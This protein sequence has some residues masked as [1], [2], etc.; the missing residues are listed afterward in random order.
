MSISRR[1]VL[2]GGLGLAGAAVLGSAA[3]CADDP[4]GQ[5][6]RLYRSE[7]PLPARFVTPFTAPPVKRPDAREDGTTRYTVVQRQAAVEILP[8]VL[9]DVYGY[10][11]LFP[12]PTIRARRGERVV[13]THRNL[14]PVPTVVHLHGGHTPAASDG[15]PTDL[16]LPEGPPPRTHAGHAGMPG[17]AGDVAH[18]T[19]DH[20]YPGDQPA[21]TLWYH[22]HRMDF[23]AP[24]V[25]RGLAGFHLIGDAD[26]DRLPLPGGERDLP[27][28]IMDR[29]FGPDGELRYP[30]LDG[31][32]TGRPG[33][34]AG[35]V[36]GVLGDVVLVNGRPWPVLDVAAARYRFRVLNASNARRYD[37][38]LDPAPTVGRA[39]V[40]VGADAGLLAEPVPHDH[41]PLARPSGTTWSSTSAPSPSAPRSPWSTPWAAGRPTR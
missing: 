4:A 17:A 31:S 32:L 29:A 12:G 3:G 11:G 33:V 2:A 19:R 36:S 34:A 38:R 24:Q 9:T 30:S 37:L 27:L 28:M 14:L 25:W 6:A 5:T 8:G 22:D 26:E 20:V 7:R 41:L 39:F 35:Y 1:A 23:T 10:D 16:L 13:V 15:F 18:G 40:Q 21:A